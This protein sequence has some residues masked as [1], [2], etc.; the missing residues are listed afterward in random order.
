MGQTGLVLLDVDDVVAHEL[1]QSIVGLRARDG[2]RAYLAHEA[3]TL[4]RLAQQ[5][6]A[7]IIRVGQDCFSE[8]GVLDAMRTTCTIV[9]I[10]RPDGFEDGD[11][12]SASWSWQRGVQWLSEVFRTRL[13]SVA[14]RVI[15]GRDRHALNIA[16]QLMTEMGCG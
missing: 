3:A 12:P 6:P 7:G 4:Q 10:S 13:P 8:P 5:R 14:D 16:R 15:D 9:Y 11:E 2:Q 1:G